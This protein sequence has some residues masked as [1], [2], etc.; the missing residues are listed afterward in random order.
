MNE[1][2]Q[3]I[4]KTIKRLLALANDNKNDEEGQA[5]FLKAQKLMLMNRISSEELGEIVEEEEIDECSVTIYKKLFWWERN[6]GSIIAKNF[7]VKMYYDDKLLRGN[8]QIK[9]KI[10]FY[11]LEKDLELAQEMFILAYDAVLVYA[12]EYINQYYEQG[13]RRYRYITESLKASYIRGFLEGLEDA[14]NKQISELRGC[15]E[16]LVLVPKKVEDAFK[17]YSSKFGLYTVS[18][19]DIESGHAYATGKEDGK[20]MDFTKSKLREPEEVKT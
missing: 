18:K 11:G 17:D 6:L 13:D 15:Y 9:S 20:K 3:K 1:D 14:F 8:T 12:K 5:A 4:I 16:V 2:N 19:P 7:R 10:V